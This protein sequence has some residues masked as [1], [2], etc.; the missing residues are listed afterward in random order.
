VEEFFSHVDLILIFAIYAMSLNLLL[1]Y[2]GQVSVAHAAFGAVGAYGA[3]YLVTVHG[4]AFGPAFLV[5]IG[6]ALLVGLL[7][8]LPALYL[9]ARFL[10]LLT[11]A[12]ST[13][14]LAVVGAIPALGG[15]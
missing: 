4:W 8:S 1:G 2:A 11:L 10:I 14:I 13:A 15:S 7:T 5:G 3:G 12:L 6:A 9:D